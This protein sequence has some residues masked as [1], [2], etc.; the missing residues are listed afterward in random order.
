MEYIVVDLSVK[1]FKFYRD[2]GLFSIEVECA[3]NFNSYEDAANICFN[4]SISSATHH[5]KLKVFNKLSYIRKEK[6]EKLENDS[7]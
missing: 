2:I 7:Y 3:K 1:N 5:R 6:L 4:Y